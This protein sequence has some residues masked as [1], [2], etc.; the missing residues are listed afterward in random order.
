MIK[1]GD[2]EV[3]ADGTSMPRLVRHGEWLTVQDG[4][5]RLLFGA[6]FYCHSTFNGETHQETWWIPVDVSLRDRKSLLGFVS[7][8]IENVKE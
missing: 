8:F 5:V 4:D 7:K 1:I 2:Y 3:K 6:L